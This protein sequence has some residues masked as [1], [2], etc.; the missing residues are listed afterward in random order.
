MTFWLHE[1]SLGEELV[2]PAPFLLLYLRKAELQNVNDISKD[3]IR[4]KSCHN[5]LQ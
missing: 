3:V 2:K 5:N 1:T 4:E